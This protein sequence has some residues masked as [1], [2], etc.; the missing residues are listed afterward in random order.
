MNN[1]IKSEKKNI[2]KDIYYFDNILPL[3]FIDNLYEKVM[4]DSYW[5]RHQSSDEDSNFF[6]ALNMDQGYDE[7]VQFLTKYI[8]GNKPLRF[9]V[10]GQSCLQHG[11][12]HDDDGERTYLLGLSKDWKGV[13]QGGA[14]EFLIKDDI[15]FSVYPVYNRMVSF[16]AKILHRALP[17][18]KFEGFRMTLAI[19][20]ELA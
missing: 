15:T 11:C 9:Y 12:F 8:E 7:E 2:T 5:T 14:T 3:E 13:E 4:S 16:P 20:T 1:Q 18:I 19:K 10:N 17:S 6:W